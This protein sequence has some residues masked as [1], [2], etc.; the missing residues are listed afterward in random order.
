[1]ASK[2]KME[3]LEQ[4]ILLTGVTPAVITVPTPILPVGTEPLQGITS[5]PNSLAPE[6]FDS[7]FG[8]SNLYFDVNGTVTPADGAGQTIAI[9]DPFVDPNIVSDVTTF[10]NFTFTSKTGVQSSIP[11]SNTDST[12]QFFLTVK[13][14]A[15]TVNTPATPPT[16]ADLEGWYEEQ[17]LDVEWA[18]AVAPGAHILL[19]EAPSDTLLDMLDANVYAA[20]QTGVVTVSDSWA[21]NDTTI[22]E[23]D[24]YDGYFV[25]PNGHEDSNA[26]LGTDAG[27]TFFAASG[28]PQQPG[29]N[30]P[31]ASINVISIGGMTWPTDVNGEWTG[32]HAPWSGSQG[33]PDPN[34]SSPKYNEP[35][36]AMDADPQTGV[37]VYDST[38][39]P[40]DGLL[41]GWNVVGGTSLATPAWAAYMSI[42]DQ[43]LG[44]Q[45][46]ASLDEDQALGGGYT[47][48]ANTAKPDVTQGGLLYLAEYSAGVA[49]GTPPAPTSDTADDFISAGEA[50]N[51]NNYP[52]WPMSVGGPTLTA[53]PSN[54]NTG[55]GA[56]NGP[57]LTSDMVGGSITQVGSALDHLTFAS[58][59]ASQTAGQALGAFTVT[60]DTSTGTVD[61]AFSGDIT[62][63]FDPNSTPGGSFTGTATLPVTNGAAEFSDVSG[64]IIDQ[65]GTYEFDASA[66]NTVGGTSTSFSVTAAAPA[67]LIIQEQPVS[68]VQTT[69]MATPVVVAVEDQYNNVVLNASTTVV[70]SINSGPV[71][72]V[73]SGQISVNTVNGVATFNGVSADLLGTY[74]LIATAGAITSPVT[75]AFTV[76]TPQLAFVE[77]PASMLLGGSMATPVEVELED[78]S[79]NLVDSSGSV[80]TLRINS[81]PAGAVLSGQTLADTVNGVA[82]FSGLSANLLGTYTLIASTNSVTSPVSSPFQ[83]ETTQLAFVDQPTSF[84]QGSS[85]AAPVVVELEDLSGNLIDSSG[86]VVTLRIDTGPAGAVLSGQT[87][88]T[89]VNGFAAFNSVSANL[90]GT[91]TLIATASG[92]TSSQSSS[93]AVG[94]AHLAFIEQ[95]VA[96]WQY[97]AM[98][99]AVTVAV[100][101]QNDNIATSYV[102]TPITLSIASGTPGSYLIP[103]GTVT[104]RTVNGE[105]IFAGLVINNAGTDTLR[106]AVPASTAISNSF[107]VVP[108]PVRQN[109]LFSE[110][111]LSSQTLLFQ[112]IR[113]AN[114]YAMPPSNAEAM[115]VLAGD[116][117]LAALLTQSP[118]G[119]VATPAFAAASDPASPSVGASVSTGA[120]S[121]QAG[122][123]YTLLG[124]ANLNGVVNSSDFNILAANFNQ[125]IAGSGQGDFN[126]DSLVR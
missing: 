70:L 62:I 86:T 31:A 56:P 98:I 58:E 51:P 26:S 123:D 102:S 119:S 19:V 16:T 106:A 101:D 72:A 46:V 124:D 54:G 52:L 47:Y 73:L 68:F 77:Q 63:S 66:P 97:A 82:T 34:Y 10:D 22:T 99:T 114:A 116:E 83:V 59:P 18:H 45:G 3:M 61:T 12:G 111:P 8:F 85:M 87:T 29:I 122:V 9:V 48:T 53:V 65:A 118:I 42:V 64:L 27:V 14:L 5:T 120:S 105:A 112:Q 109:S 71:G 55:F 49:R 23:P 94:A 84:L 100:E 76:E 41:A 115:A 60:V 35:L 40:A 104:V 117:Q 15:A 11:L 89:A 7:S 79:G 125:S 36:F 126:Y 96:T 74:T 80:V 110:V 75:S 20:Q 24:T 90:V 38:S 44:L 108:V 69:S 92:A 103:W 30:F 21:T 6:A 50:A 1:M 67:K 17:A 39:D 57:S 32:L 91:Y 81:G 37:W 93:F 28:D 121:G 2:V 88:A 113:I 13:P 78:Q 107:A 95:P 25:T 43:G 33:G 4:R